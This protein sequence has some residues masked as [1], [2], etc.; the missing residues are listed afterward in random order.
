MVGDGEDWLGV[1][2][3]GRARAQPVANGGKLACKGLLIISSF[4]TVPLACSG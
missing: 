3:Q 4:C 1:M 2:F